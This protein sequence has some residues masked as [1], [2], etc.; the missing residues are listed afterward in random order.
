MSEFFVEPSWLNAVRGKRFYY[1]AAN[2][3][4]L[5]ALEVFHEVIDEFWFADIHYR[6]GL[7]MAPALVGDQRFRL[8]QVLKTGAIHAAREQRQ[9]TLGQSF[10]YLEPSRLIER[11]EKRDG[12]NLTVVRRRGYGQ[13]GLVEEFSKKDLGV[14]MHRGDSPGEGGS[15]VWFLANCK[16]RYQPCGMLFDKL[17]TRLADESL[18]VSDGSNCDIK[19]LKLFHNKNTN[20]EEAFNHHQGRDFDFHGFHWRCV[21]WLNQRYGPTLVWGL[22]RIGATDHHARTPPRTPA[23]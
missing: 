7:E 4:H 9:D 11:Y 15:N 14:F 1:P 6:A 23:P 18:I 10:G 16:S 8:L 19:R 21:G 20:G 5:E 13:I 22:R 3:D 17:A 12:R 2:L